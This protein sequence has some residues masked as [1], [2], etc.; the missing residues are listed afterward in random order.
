MQKV[1]MED[2]MSTALILEDEPLIAMDV[3]MT[4]REMGYDVSVLGECAEAMAWLKTR[5]PDLAI[6]DVMLR[7]GPCHAVV[8]QLGNEGV[9]FIVHSGDVSDAH[10]G[11]PYERG[12]WLSKPS[13]REH[14]VTAISQALSHR[15]QI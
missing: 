15:H 4:L 12:V 8:E 10:K 6:V 11:T 5:R 3:E 9:P 2:S 7:D 13:L 14:F 1:W